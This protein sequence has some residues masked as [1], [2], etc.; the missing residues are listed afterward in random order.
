[1]NARSK[2]GAYPHDDYLIPL[3]LY[4][5]WQGELNDN[6]FIEALKQSTQVIFNQAVAEG[7]P[8]IAGEKQIKYGNYASGSEG[9]GSIYGNNLARLK[10]VKSQL[11]P[12]NVM[13][14][15]G[16]YRF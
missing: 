14:L 6:F 16:G 1:M 5:A 11:D 12:A 15:A 13:S 8:H 9:L 2:G 4:F 10:A 3:N 7:Q